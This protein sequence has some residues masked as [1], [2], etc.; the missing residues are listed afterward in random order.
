ML[1]KAFICTKVQQNRNIVKYYLKY[2]TNNEFNMNIFYKCNLFLYVFLPYSSLQC[3]SDPL[4]I[5]ICL[6]DA[7]LLSV[8]IGAQLLIMV[9]IELKTE[10]FA[11]WCLWKQ[12]Y[13]FKNTLL[14]RKFKRTVFIYNR[15]HF[16]TF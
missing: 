11:D 4:K 6:L 7:Q 10:M 9:V 3:H 5:L 16:L 13:I 1:T 8:I 15:N 2:I 12:W 14:N